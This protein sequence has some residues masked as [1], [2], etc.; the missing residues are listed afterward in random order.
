MNSQLFFENLPFKPD[1]SQVIYVEEFYDE[2]AN[3]FITDN[4][5]DLRQW[6]E[7]RGYE[8]IYLPMLFKD[9]E[10]KRKVLYYAPYLQADIVE[11]KSLRSNYL[12]KLLNHSPGFQTL[13]PSLLFNPERRGNKWVFQACELLLTGN[14]MEDIL[15]MIDRICSGTLFL[16]ECSA[17]NESV[18]M[19]YQPSSE[20]RSSMIIESDEKR[21]A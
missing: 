1:K 8:F 7:Y 19:N 12:L 21:S 6:F 18:L 14:D 15:Q 20:P 10:L 3:R 16:E 5:H 2:Q 4:Y 13:N 9:E 17:A 11:D